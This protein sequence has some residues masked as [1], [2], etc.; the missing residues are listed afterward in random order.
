VTPSQRR[1]QQTTGGLKKPHQGGKYIVY[2]KPK[3][4]KFRIQG[5]AP[6]ALIAASPAFGTAQIS[7]QEKDHRVQLALR[8]PSRH[9]H[10]LQRSQ[11]FRKLYH[12]Q[13]QDQAAASDEQLCKTPA[14]AGASDQTGAAPGALAVRTQPRLYIPAI[15]SGRPPQ[16]KAH[17]F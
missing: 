6:V 14:G 12:A 5:I 11:I 4:S 16:I 13:W 8:W 7:F 9:T 15:N 17:E 2:R 10:S 3:H 1:K